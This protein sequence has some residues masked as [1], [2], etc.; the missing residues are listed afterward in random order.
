LSRACLGKMIVFID[1][2]LKKICVFRTDG[3]LRVDGQVPRPCETTQKRLF[4]LPT[5]RF[6]FVPSLSWSN[7]R[8]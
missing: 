1:E 7:D 5:F 2:L 8:H 3:L 6:M 4:C